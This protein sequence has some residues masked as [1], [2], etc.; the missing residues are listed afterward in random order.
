MLSPPS[1][2]NISG[3]ARRRTAL[4]LFARVLVIIVL[5]GAAEGMARDGA[6]PSVLTFAELA[7]CP[8][9]MGAD[10][11]AASLAKG[12]SGRLASL[13]G[14][15]VEITGYM[16]PVAIAHG[17]SREFLLMRNQN[18]CCYGVPPQPNEYLVVRTT[19]EEGVSVVMD[20]PVAFIGTF[21]LAPVI[22]QGM[23]LQV[24]TLEKAVTSN[25]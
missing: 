11:T 16:L 3:A 4:E 25:R 7:A 2:A 18:S 17:K 14:R 5:A 9:K 8:L 24:F 19:A 20:Q 13:N 12:F 23:I 6:A 15:S 22:E 21:T 1:L 10:Q